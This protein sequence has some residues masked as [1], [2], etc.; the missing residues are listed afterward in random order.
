MHMLKLRKYL[1][2]AATVAL[3]ITAA[4]PVHAKDLTLCWA[5]WDPANALVELSKDFTTKMGIA[6][7]FEF[8]PWP[9]FADRFI[10]ELNSKGK[11]CDLMIGDSQWIGGSATQ[12]HYVK[13]NDFFAKEGIKMDDFLPA[14]VYAYSTWP[15]GTPNYWALPAMGDANG[16][17]YR[18]DWFSRPELRKE[19]KDK[20]KRELAPP[21][22]WTELKD[23]GEFFQGRTIDGKKV[24]GAAIFTERGSEGITMGVTSALYPFG[25]KY[26]D[27]KKPYHMDGYVNSADAVAALEFYKAVYKCCTPPG[28]TNAYMQEGLDAFKSGQVAMMMNW[29]AF[30]PGLYKDPN[31]GGNKIGFFVNPKQKVEG[32]TLG[33]QGISVVAYSDRKEDA[34]KYIKWFAQPDV[35]KKWWALGGY[36]CHKAVLLDPNF[37]KSAPFAG[38]FLKAMQNVQDFWQ[39]PAYAELLLDM[40]KRVHDYVVADKGTA[41]EALDL[42]IK[43]WNKVFKEEGKLVAEKQ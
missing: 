14:T 22:T 6:M 38:D 23:I 20:Y 25:F 29:F 4:I 21:A 34:L 10:N 18:K 40:Q 33:G 28:Y 19:F 2:G 12:G 1:V 17:V 26:D 36:S 9:N 8:V 24:Y 5:A 39:E 43:D 16:W 37:P 15:K 35:Q 3:G 13:L 31:V 30:F 7:K 41:K 42:L 11:L 27:P 32:S